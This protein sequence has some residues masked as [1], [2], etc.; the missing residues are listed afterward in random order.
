MEEI[1]DALTVMEFAERK[2][3]QPEVILR[4]ITLKEIIPIEIGIDNIHD[5]TIHPDYL[6]T[7]KT[8][9]I[10]VAEYAQRMRVTER[11]IYKKID[12]KKITYFLDPI[13]NVMKIDWVKYKDIHF[14]A[15]QYKHKGKNRLIKK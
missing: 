5:C 10:G 12:A 15:V 9:L 2:N 13:S 3:V 7:F 4:A 8:E 14:R 1:E 11:A 6:D